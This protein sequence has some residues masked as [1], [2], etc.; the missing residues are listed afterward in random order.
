[1][2]CVKQITF[3]RRIGADNHGQWIGKKHLGPF[4]GF[5][6][7]NANAF[8]HNFNDTGST[9]SGRILHGRIFING[10]FMAVAPSR[11]ARPAANATGNRE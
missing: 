9:S 10:T 1:L 6:I 7:L 4:Q 11:A 3:P 2:N 8:D 5:V